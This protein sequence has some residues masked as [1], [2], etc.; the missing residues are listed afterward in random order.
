MNEILGYLLGAI[1]IASASVARSL[2]REL[3]TFC[4]TIILEKTSMMKAT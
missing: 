3:A 4:P 2:F 1:A